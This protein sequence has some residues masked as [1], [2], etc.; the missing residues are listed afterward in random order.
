MKGFLLGTK[1]DFVN[2]VNTTYKNNPR[3]KNT[4]LI[5]GIPINH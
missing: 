4:E 5:S 2:A 1:G 3:K